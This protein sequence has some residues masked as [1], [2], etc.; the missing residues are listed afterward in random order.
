MTDRDLRRENEALRDRISALSTASLRI[1]ASLVL[2]TV[3]REVL[4]S[5]RS[6]TDAHFGAIAIIDQ[7]GAPQDFVTSGFTEA[8]HRVM[9]EWS[10]GPRLTTVKSCPA[11]GFH[12]GRAQRRVDVP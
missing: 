9:V 11:V 10:E 3:L 6:L 5:A 12:S 4:E 2:E 7:A 1:S 8:E